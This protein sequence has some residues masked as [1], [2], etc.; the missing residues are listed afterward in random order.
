MIDALCSKVRVSKSKE[1]CRSNQLQRKSICS[2]RVHWRTPTRDHCKK[3]SKIYDTTHHA[4]QRKS[5][6]INQ[7]DEVINPTVLHRM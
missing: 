2:T 7:S 4:G 6:D 3:S 1:A 5:R